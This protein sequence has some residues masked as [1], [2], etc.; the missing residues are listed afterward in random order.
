MSTNESVTE[1]LRFFLRPTPCSV[2]VGGV[3]MVV[4][5]CGGTDSATESEIS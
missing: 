5:I 2:R 1:F 3:V 4:G